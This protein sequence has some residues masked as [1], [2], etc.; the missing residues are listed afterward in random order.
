MTSGTR[1]TIS[2]AHPASRPLGSL[3]SRTLVAVILIAVFGSL[4]WADATRLAAAPAGCWLLPAAVLAAVAGAGE[5]VALASPHGRGRQSLVAMLGAAAIVVAGFLGSQPGGGSLPASLS[6]LGA[7]ALAAC[8]AIALAF[9]VEVVGY[10]A[11]GGAVQRAATGSLAAICLGLPFAFMLG[12]RLCSFDR[13]ADEPAT[14]HRPGTLLPLLSFVAVVK[15]GDIAAYLVG[16]MVGRHRMAPNLSPGKTW[17][18]AVG[19]LVGAVAAAWLALEMLGPS[20]LDRL[21]PTRPWGGWPVYGLLLGTA[22]ILGDL[23]ESLVKRE[24]GAKDSGRWLGGMGGMLDLVDS[25][26]LTA[27]VAWLLWVAGRGV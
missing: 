2:E 5:A 23:C 13:A 12:L 10:R 21:P 11:G 7:V 25:L 8:L 6:G 4:V 26:L 14:A 17:E 24:Y 3:L 15:A 27:P 1:P 20:P 16:S 22:G 19:G 9:T 18:G